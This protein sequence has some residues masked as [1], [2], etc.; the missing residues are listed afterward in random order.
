MLNPCLWPSRPLAVQTTTDLDSEK[1]KL[2]FSKFKWVR[3]LSY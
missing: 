1:Q 3:L 2:D